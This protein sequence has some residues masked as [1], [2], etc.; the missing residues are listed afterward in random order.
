[1]AKEYIEPEK[2]YEDHRSSGVVF[3]ALGIVGVIVSILSFF[4]ILKFPLSRF[5]ILILLTA[6]VCSIVLGVCS[7]KRASQIKATILT[8]N[9]YVA[10]IRSWIE[11]N[12]D[13]FCTSDTAGMSGSEIYFQREYDIR[14]A[15]SNQFPDME[16]EL[17]DLLVEETYQFLFEQN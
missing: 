5:Q 13:G 16:E 1:M 4:N 11:Q 7:F 2:R 14:E 8:E 15:I 9:D 12:R 6:F 3:T 17:L 10:S